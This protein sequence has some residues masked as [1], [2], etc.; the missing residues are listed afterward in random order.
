MQFLK[1]KVAQIVMMITITIIMV[2]V[3][4]YTSSSNPVYA[5][6]TASIK[7]VQEEMKKVQV[8]IDELKAAMEEQQTEIE[9]LKTENSNLKTKIESI[10]YDSEIKDINNKIKSINAR[11]TYLYDKG[12]T[13]LNLNIISRYI[14]D[15]LK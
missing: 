1:N 2:G 14:N 8:Q 5:D 11:E 9:T 3:I 15:N 7:Y 10:N 6:D 13:G 4:I 12:S